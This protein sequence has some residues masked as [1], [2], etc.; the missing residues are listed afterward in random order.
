M[1]IIKITA[2]VVSLVLLILYI[3]RETITYKLAETMI[4]KNLTRNLVSELPDGLHVFLCGAGSPMIDPK[5]S[6]PCTAVIVGNNVFIVDAGNATS[7]N[8]QLGRVPIGKVEGIF[9]THF[10]SDHI[11]GL[12]ELIMQRWANGS[13]N[14]PVEVYG[15]EGVEKVVSGFNLAYQQDDSY[16]IAHHGEATM[17]PSGGNGLAK[18]FKQPKEGESVKVYQQQGITVSAFKVNHNPIEPAV[19]YRFDYKGRS[20]VISGDTVKS[21]NVAKH[22]QGVDVLLHEALSITLVNFINKQTKK[23]GRDNLVKITHDITDYHTTP[24][25]AAEIAEQ[26]KVKHL[27]FN[28]IVPPLRI[29]TMEEIFLQGVEEAFSG[30]YTL[31][32]DGTLISLPANSDDIIVEELLW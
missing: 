21:T 14:T 11:D 2:V 4:A 22:S 6:G 19:G 10:H 3:N 28:H 17:P 30:D 8:L 16:R 26:A 25:Q 7:K 31:G 18:A 13:R 1:K 32:K 24:V 29:A 5:R 9:L 15:P 27:V 23:A 20:L 12:G